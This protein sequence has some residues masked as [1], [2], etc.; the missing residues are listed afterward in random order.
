MRR[1]LLSLLIFITVLYGGDTLR[2]A[3]MSD[4]HTSGASG[5][6][7][8]AR[9]VRDINNQENIDFAI[10]SGDLT[11]YDF[12]GHNRRA[13]ELLDSL[14]VPWHAIPGNHEYK[15][16]YSAGEE[17]L[18]HFGDDK[19]NKKIGDFRFIGYHQGP[20]LRIRDLGAPE[21]GVERMAG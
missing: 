11:D 20:L 9:A 2:F 18:K 7:D 1:L 14:N 4:T 21:S 3:W 8:L 16:T 19:F 10:V 15:W 5:Q 12:P 13:K 17:Y 6:R